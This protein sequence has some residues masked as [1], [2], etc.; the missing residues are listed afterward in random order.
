MKEE[1]GLENYDYGRRGSVALTTWHPL[2]TNVDTNF[3]E[4]RGSLG[5]CS[6][7]SDSSHG[8]C[9][10]LFCC[11]PYTNVNQHIPSCKRNAVEYE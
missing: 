4:K 10:F 7:L 11:Y 9:L 3:V 6:S 5:R 8:V 1:V 2:S